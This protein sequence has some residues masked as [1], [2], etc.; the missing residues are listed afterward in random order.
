MRIAMII[1]A[2]NP[3]WGG[4]QVHVL[5]ISKE[6]TKNYN[7]EIDIFTM[8][9]LDKKNEEQKMIEE[10]FSNKIRIIRIGEKRKF[11][12]KDRILWIF[13]S[14]KTIKKYHINKNYD[15]IHAHANLPGIPGKILSKILKIPVV[16][17]VHGTNF[18][19][20]KKRNL[21]Y[22]IEKILFT[23]IKYDREISVTKCF[24]KYKNKNS[25]VFIPNGV[26]AKRFDKKREFFRSFK[27][28]HTF[29]LLFVGRLDYVKGIDIL[30]KSIKKI[31]K[32]LEENNAKLHLVGYGYEEESLKKIRHSLKIEKIVEFLG[33]LD[34]DELLKEYITSDLFILPSRTE[35]FPLTLLEAWAAKL[36]VIATR[37][38]DNSFL[39]ENQKNGFL[40]DPESSKELARIILEV[41]DN[42]KLKGIGENGYFK[43]K[44][45]YKWERIAK[46]TYE[47]YLELSK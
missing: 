37:V 16:Y 40:I 8:N 4:G 22:F 32:E 38:G 24:L 13:E 43:V 34:G 2:W 15:L 31:K 39:I 21:F 11:S 29:K 30:L 47:K 7:C 6:L 25:P 26:D 35:G 33:R 46:M 23:K 9:L 27:D 36:P 5:E 3:I 28:N 19:D 44:E 41:L 42:K 14:V 12:F 17:T 10:L 45:K 1:E 20:L 18:L